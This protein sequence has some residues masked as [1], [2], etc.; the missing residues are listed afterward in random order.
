[1]DGFEAWLIPKLGRFV[2]PK[3]KGD[4]DPIREG[5]ETLV[6]DPE[7]AHRPLAAE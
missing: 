2:T 1:M 3:R 5:E 4:D 6:S 7:G